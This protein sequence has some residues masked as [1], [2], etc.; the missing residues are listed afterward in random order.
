MADKSTKTDLDRLSEETDAIKDLSKE[1]MKF[2]KTMS[3]VNKKNADDIGKTVEKLKESELIYEKIEA[4][5]LDINKSLSVQAASDERIRTHMSS[6]EELQRTQKKASEQIDELTEK[7]RNKKDKENKLTMEGLETSKRVR[8]EYLAMAA[9]AGAGIIRAQ[10]QLDYA[11]KVKASEE[12]RFKVTDAAVKKLKEEHALLEKKELH[13]RVQSS[14]VEKM[15]GGYLEKFSKSDMSKI[16]GLDKVITKMSGPVKLAFE[17]VLSLINHAWKTFKLFDEDVFRLRKNLGLMGKQ[18]AEVQR[19]A[20]LIAREYASIGVTITQSVDSI[21]SLSKALGSVSSLSKEMVATTAAF[22]SQL[23][24]SEDTTANVQKNL[25]QISGKSIKDAT[26]GMMGFAQSMAVAAEV[27][28]PEVMNDLANM[29]DTVRST[30]R[31]NTVELIKATVEARRMGLSIE[32]L[33]KTS[34]GLLDFNQSVNSEMEASVLLGKNINFIEAR[35]KAFAGDILGA[36]KEILKT[37]KSV[38]DFD[39]LNMFQKKALAQATGKTVEELQSM[40]QREKN[41]ELV[42]ASGKGAAY[43]SLMLYEKQMKLKEKESQDVGKAAEADILKMANQAKMTVLQQQFNQLMMDLAGPIMDIM[44]PLLELATKVLPMIINGVKMLGPIATFVWGI[45]KGI[46]T[47]LPMVSKVAIFFGRW[48]SPIG[49]IITALAVISKTMSKWKEFPDGFMG[50]LEAIWEGLYDVLVKPFVDAYD[51]IA[52]IFVGKSPSKLGLSIVKG[53]ES[54][55]TMLLDVLMYPFKSAFTFITELFGKIP[56][57]ISSVFK[58]GIDFAMKLPGMG[59]LMKAMDK[60]SG[61]TPT[62][63]ATDAVAKTAENDTNQ[64]VLAKLTELVDLMR[65][66]GITINLDGRRVSEALAHAS[67]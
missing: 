15:F 57:F 23:G 44:Q 3:S 11:K 55:G 16:L 47:I 60:L 46:S 50:G 32:S 52:S 54:V 59:M 4:H 27:P 10:K 43:D 20:R 29:S 65:T 38:G 42:R 17:V 45:G 34:E 63:N 36:N 8:K 13:T 49:W 6:I 31:G 24:I 19:T 66:G 41:I 40:L 64:L 51:W 12:E 62:A 30:F 58:R 25:T 2:G 39:K 5:Q 22:A 53:I 26:T 48:F 1:M 67:R 33:G 18:G 56:E 28:L 35:R 7:I 37:V 61:T 14:L 9:D 21:T